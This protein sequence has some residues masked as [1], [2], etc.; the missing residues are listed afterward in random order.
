MNEYCVFREEQTNLRFIIECEKER[1]KDVRFSMHLSIPFKNQKEENGIYTAT[2]ELSDYAQKELKKV[3]SGK[4]GKIT[5]KYVPDNAEFSLYNKE[6]KIN[7]SMDETER[8]FRDYKK[9][10]YESEYE[11]EQMMTK[12][13]QERMMQQKEEEMER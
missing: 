6:N 4:I 1:Q 9:S 5:C 13:A 11:F 2:A 8:L 3:I 10:F 7:L 12:E